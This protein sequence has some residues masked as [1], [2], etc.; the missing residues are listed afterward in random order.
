MSDEGHDPQLPLSWHKSFVL[1]QGGYN[2]AIKHI[3]ITQIGEKAS[4]RSCA[5]LTALPRAPSMDS[6]ANMGFGE[7]RE[8][9][10]RMCFGGKRRMD[11]WQ[12][13]L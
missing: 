2:H 4:I 1:A 7:G 10:G 8:E 13:G 3:C 5:S 11:G 6:T 12:V 9:A